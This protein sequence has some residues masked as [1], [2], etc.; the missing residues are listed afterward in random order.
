MIGA[1]VLVA[2]CF[3][4]SYAAEWTRVG[5]VPAGEFLS[6]YVGEDR[7]YAGGAGVVYI[8]D[9]NNRSWTASKPVS[10]TADH[11][12]AIIAAGNR[13]FAGT[14]YEGV[15]EST[16]GGANW[17]PRND[18]LTELGA[19]VPNDF[20]VR[21]DSLYMATDGAGV[22]V[23][24]LGGSATW[25]P[26]R[27]GLDFGVEWNVACL[28]DNAGILIAGAGA[29]GMIATRSRTEA[30]WQSHQFSEFS[31]APLKMLGAVA[32]DG[33]VY[34][35]ASNGLYRSTDHGQNW[36]QYLTGIGEISDAAVAQGANRICA[37]VSK[38]GLGT[39]IYQ[40]TEETWT[41]VDQLGIVET[42]DM[43]I[44]GNR[45]YLARTDGLWYTNLDLTDAPEE[46][47]V[48]R[49][50][51]LAQNYPNP[52]NL[53]TAIAFTTMQPGKVQLNVYN[54]L[55][56]LVATLVD[57]EIVAGAHTVEWTGLNASGEAVPSGIYFYRLTVD[58][59][60]QTR[61]MVVLK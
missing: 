51:S 13:L 46:E 14:Y 9:G 52:F 27:E 11:I 45:M 40:W 59:V 34:G 32:Q 23:L 35:A 20:V 10:E 5:E 57:R 16:D 44:F 26:Y 18:G 1:T 50:M 19:K 54:V 28:A 47:P 29:N 38:M 6:L 8:Y 7:L 60:T 37:A 39:Q 21:G 30:E 42:W 31:G 58:G 49:E 12:A 43:T 53:S 48:P 15:F 56:Q 61:K 25:A 33:V 17:T 3:S 22:Y 36:D 24:N 41:Q 2:A 55:G 4:A